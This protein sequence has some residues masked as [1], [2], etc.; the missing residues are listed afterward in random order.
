MSLSLDFDHNF[1]TVCCCWSAAYGVLFSL[2]FHRGFL[3][4]LER[5]LS[6]NLD[7]SFAE[8]GLAH[9]NIPR[10]ATSELGQKRA[11]YLAEHARLPR[12]RRV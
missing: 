1:C 4:L 9:S 12:N 2:L 10:E 7:I 6:S 8:M 11:V 5:I 3:S